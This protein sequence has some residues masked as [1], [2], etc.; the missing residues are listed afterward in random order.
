MYML[1][2]PQPMHSTVK[3]WFSS[4]QLYVL[5]GV[6][7]TNRTVKFICQ[8]TTQGSIEE[9][10]VGCTNHAVCDLSFGL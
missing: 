7:R 10:L 8:Y 2:L 1:E 5:G 6:K 4:G 9:T 3:R